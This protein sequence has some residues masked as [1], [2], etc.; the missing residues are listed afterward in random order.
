[1]HIAKAVRIDNRFM[2][3]DVVVSPQN[4]KKAAS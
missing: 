1:M 3:G 4:R 2:A